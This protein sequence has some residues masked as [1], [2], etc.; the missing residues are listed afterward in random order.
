MCSVTVVLIN[1]QQKVSEELSRTKARQYPTTNQNA[2]NIINNEEGKWD[3]RTDFIVCGVFIAC[4]WSGK[5]TPQV[6]VNPFR[7][8]VPFWGQ[9]TQILSK[10]SP[11]RDCSSE[12]VKI[13][14]ACFVFSRQI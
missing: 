11:K 6:V 8:A 14:S 9:P 12:R 3:I 13:V 2:I 7:T 4:M 5:K 10:L 1:D